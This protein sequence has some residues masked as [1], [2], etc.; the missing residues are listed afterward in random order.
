MP[1]VTANR[2]L[3]FIDNLARVL[4][5]GETTAGA[6]DLV[7]VAARHGIELLGPPGVM[8]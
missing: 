7:E 3:W 5:D 6:L 8:P 4:A 1:A 2:P